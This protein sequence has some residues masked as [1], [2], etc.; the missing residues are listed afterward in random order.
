M[1]IIIL[2]WILGF[3]VMG[4]NIYYLAT[5][6]VN[7]LLH[8]DLPKVGNVFIGIIVFPLM[9]IYLLAVV[10]LTFRKDTVVTF[11]DQDNSGPT[12]GGKKLDN[13]NQIFELNHLSSRE[14]L[15]VHPSNELQ[16]S[17]AQCQPGRGL[18]D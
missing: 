13:S 12:H 17:P 18:G 15:V 6:F 4:V 7:W 5:G 2:S 3:G 1:Q 11:I 10:Y 9:A 14:D 8:N 16:F